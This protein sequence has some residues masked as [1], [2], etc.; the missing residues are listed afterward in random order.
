MHA[1]HPTISQFVIHTDGSCSGN[2]GPGGYAAILRS[3]CGNT[4]V[5]EIELSGGAPLT[6]NNQQEL[7]ACIVALEHLADSGLDT[8]T[9][10]YVCSDSEYVVEGIRTRLPKWKANGWRTASKSPVKNIE[11][12]Q[13]LDALCQKLSVYAHHVLGHNGDAMNERADALAR[14]AMETFKTSAA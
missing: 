11:L 6:T 12:W 9:P 8:A 3:F 14:T 5:D 1:I 13:R 2:P 4:I 10:V 7:L